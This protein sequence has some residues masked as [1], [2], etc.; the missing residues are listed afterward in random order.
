MPCVCR[1]VGCAICRL[2]S[3]VDAAAVKLEQQSAAAARSV[4]EECERHVAAERALQ[5]QV[6]QLSS[7]LA[8][9]QVGVAGVRVSAVLGTVSFA[10]CSHNCVPCSWSIGVPSHGYM[11]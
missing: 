9:S 10:P 3:Q 1:C 11:A 2:Q 7:E 5:Q 8:V 4:A 6:Q